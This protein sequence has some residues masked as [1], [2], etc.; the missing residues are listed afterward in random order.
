MLCNLNETTRHK[1]CMNHMNKKL[2]NQQLL[3]ELAERIVAGKLEIDKP[4]DWIIKDKT[5]IEIVK[6]LKNKMGLCNKDGF[7]LTNLS[8]IYDEKTNRNPLNLNYFIAKVK[9]E[10]KKK[11]E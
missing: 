2:T 10:I 8:E 7:A 5:P 9:N 6:L 3:R 11:Y 1:S 4:Q